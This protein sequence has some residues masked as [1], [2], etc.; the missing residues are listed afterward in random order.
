MSKLAND[1]SIDGS[2]QGIERYYRMH[3]RIYDATR[4]SFLFGRR[5]I[6]ANIAAIR[7]PRR[8]L[9]VGC[10]TGTNLHNLCRNFPAA[11]ITGVD[12][13][14]DM[15]GVARKNLQH[16]I[17]PPRLIQRAYSEPLQA[18]E[19]FDLVVFSYALSMFNPGWERAIESARRDLSPGGIIT[20][21]DFHHSRFPWFRNWMGVN[22][23]RME[24][25]LLPVLEHHFST[26]QCQVHAA[27]A[28]LWQWFQFIG[29]P[30]QDR[31]SV[32]RSQ[33]D[34][35]GIKS[36]IAMHIIDE[37]YQLDPD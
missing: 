20:V 23:V 19:P 31:P 14:A 36:Q 4:W 33:I 16:L 2:A 3:A 1:K 37:A 21:V 18:D 26:E 25:H 28:G 9:E 22:H 17:R 6:V 13:S 5:S 10:G 32:T 7:Q 11:E 35:S 34:K 30:W 24:S 12:L 27:Y 8:I 15:L 29:T